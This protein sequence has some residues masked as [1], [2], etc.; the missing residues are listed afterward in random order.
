MGIIVVDAAEFDHW[1]DAIEA[2]V[3]ES[4]VD[5]GGLD[6]RIRYE[7]PDEYSW[8]Y[9]CPDCGDIN[10]P[11]P[12]HKEVWEVFHKA[13]VLCDHLRPAWVTPSPE[14]KKRLTGD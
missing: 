10:E 11:P 8:G 7:E 1:A 5:T 2:A 9:Y 3:K 13:C 6:V 14:L 4:G 12:N